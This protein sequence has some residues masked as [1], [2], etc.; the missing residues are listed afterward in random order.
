LVPF[1]LV[2]VG[3]GLLGGMHVN[4]CVLERTLPTAELLRSG[5]LQQL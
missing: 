2:S 1:C 3:P 5:S 4:L